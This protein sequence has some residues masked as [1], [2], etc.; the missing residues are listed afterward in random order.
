MGDE[1]AEGTGWMD[2]YR[3]DLRLLEH[4]RA[5]DTL[6]LYTFSILGWVDL[7]SVLKKLRPSG[8]CEL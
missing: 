7:G 5:V 1:G 4:L 8:T 3:L 2:G 6:Y